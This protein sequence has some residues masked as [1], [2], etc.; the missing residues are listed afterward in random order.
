MTT[1]GDALPDTIAAI[2]TPSGQGAIGIIRVSGPLAP[3]AGRRLFRP[4][5]GVCAWQSHHAY[6]GDLLSAD[7]QIVLDEVLVILMRA[8]HSFTGE[9]VLEISGHGNPVIL[10]S[11]L[12]ALMQLGCRPAKPGEFSRRAFLSGRMDL[13][14][15]E[16]L[17]AMIS[18]RSARAF[19][20]GLAQCK[21]GLGRTLGGIRAK[22]VEGLAEL[23]AAIDFIDDAVTSDASQMAAPLCD[24]L[25]SIRQLISTYASSQ[26]MTDGLSCVITGKPNVG[27]SSLLNALA[28]TKKAIVTDMPGT[29]RDLIVATTTLNGVTVHLTDTAG[30]RPP[31]DAIEKEGI[32][33]VWE[34]LE[35]AHIIVILLDGSR[36]LSDED[37]HILT[38]NSARAERVIL[39]VNKADLPAVWPT[40]AA[41][42]PYFPHAPLATISAKSG[43]G[44]DA[45]KNMISKK[46]GIED[47]SD[48]G[49]ILQL[50]HKLALERALE[51]LSAACGNLTA[52][53]SPELAAFELREAIDALDAI[54]GEKI[55]E[56]VLDHIFSTFCIGK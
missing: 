47:I 15:A 26:M 28:G 36:P 6:Y 22:L 39:A 14:Q 50:R 41:L 30:I 45:L 31:Q 25:H 56:E 49:F 27:K 44:L 20:M 42:R 35:G 32:D 37:R 7:G 2:A 33:L 23:E 29:T 48:T 11:I 52:S 3:H 24:A 13:S 53:F 17:A 5:R 9:D 1:L 46:A 21:G 34:H 54:T 8:P 4:A 40:Q 18:A 43:V 10:Q 38:E 55:S 51:N 12:E 16:G 19:Q